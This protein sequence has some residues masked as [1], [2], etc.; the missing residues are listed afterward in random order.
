ML[1]RGV[2][3]KRCR[4]VLEKSVET[5]WRGVLDRSVGEGIWREVL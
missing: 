5:C 2:V 4:E 3:E 1:E